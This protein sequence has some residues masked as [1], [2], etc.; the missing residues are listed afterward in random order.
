LPNRD[1]EM[2]ERLVSTWPLRRRVRNRTR[3]GQKSLL[4]GSLVG[5]ENVRALPH[6]L[7]TTAGASTR[8][9]LRR[10][11]LTASALMT[12]P[13][14]LNGQQPTDE[15]FVTKTGTKY[16]RASCSSLTRSN[17]EMTLA[18]ASARYS[19]CKTCKPAVLLPAKVVGLSSPVSARS[20]AQRSAT[21]EAGRC[22]AT[23]KKGTNAPDARSRG[24]G[25]V[26][27]TEG[28]FMACHSFHLKSGQDP[29]LS[30]WDSVST[31]AAFSGLRAWVVNS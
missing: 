24:A 14:G 3:A 12:A 7:M 31:L 9:S 11:A 20:L 2:G 22:Q 30:S 19:P 16:H 8:S 28:H 17:I 1:A 29:L 26:G 18:D 21:V 4:D 27:N 15:V 10:L 6:N 23:T 25:F 13:A 5:P